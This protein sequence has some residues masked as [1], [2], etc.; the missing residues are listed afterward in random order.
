MQKP[1]IQP[2]IHRSNVDCACF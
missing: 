2:Y 1:F